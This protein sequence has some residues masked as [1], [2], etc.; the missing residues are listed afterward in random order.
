LSS[1]GKSTKTAQQAS[2]FKVD[3]FVPNYT[4]TYRQGF[5]PTS[6]NEQANISE[7]IKWQEYKSSVAL[8]QVLNSEKPATA[9]WAGSTVKDVKN[10][11]ARNNNHS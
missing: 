11:P 1:A 6:R 2:Q 9:S 7:R 8:R 5:N 10:Y 3:R 4:E